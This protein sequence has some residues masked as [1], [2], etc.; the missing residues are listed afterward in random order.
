MTP[1][2]TSSPVKEDSKATRYT[3]IYKNVEYDATDY[4]GRHPGGADFIQNMKEE[5]SD[6][7]E[8]F[9][10]DSSQLR[11]LHSKQAEKILESFPVVGHTRQSSAS[12]DYMEL[13][14]KVEHLYQPIW[15]MELGI[16]FMLALMLYVAHTSDIFFVSVIMFAVQQIITGWQSHSDAHSRHPTV[17]LLGT[18]H[19]V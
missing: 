6:L 1:P 11:S 14:R 9:K 4:L 5:R 16:W 19:F 2:Q 13:L 3:F 10:Y 12:V 8:Y 15:I 17:T 18:V 7:T